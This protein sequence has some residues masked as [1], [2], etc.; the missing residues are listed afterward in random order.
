MFQRD[1]SGHTPNFSNFLDNLGEGEAEFEM[2]I[3]VGPVQ[4]ATGSPSSAPT[5]DKKLRR[6]DSVYDTS[7]LSSEDITR[8]NS[9]LDYILNIVG[10]TVAE[11]TIKETIVNCDY[12]AEVALNRILEGGA[13]GSSPLSKSSPPKRSKV[14]LEVEEAKKGNVTPVV[15]QNNVSVIGFQAKP[16]TIKAE[17]TRSR[18]NSPLPSRLETLSIETPKKGEQPGELASGAPTPQKTVVMRKTEV[19]VRAE[20]RKLRGDSKESINLI[21]IGHVDSGKSTLMGHLLFQLGQVS[22]KIMHKYEQESRKVGKQSFMYAWVL[23]ETEEERSRGITMDVGQNKF[24]TSQRVV[25]LLDAPGHRDFIP[26]MISGAYQADVAILV[27]N[28]TTGEF[29]AGFESGGQTREH[30][31]LVRS[32]GVSQLCVAINK[33]DTVDWDQ[34]RFTNIKDKLRLFLTKQAGFKETDLSFV[35]C[36]GLTGENLTQTRQQ[37]S[38]GRGTKAPH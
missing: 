24:E 6:M 18:S 1:Q 32:L 10:E 29:E 28:A 31:L 19:D 16:E 9:C 30:A 36:S 14:K 35:P 38:L 12:N 20:Y 4:E 2:D 23:D 7:A 22:Q 34:E 17:Q 21:V 8:L 3:G 13:G 26:N 5:S 25:T 27:V 15:K 11:Y 37:R 33:L